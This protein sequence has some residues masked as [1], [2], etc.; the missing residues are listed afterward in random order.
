MFVSVCLLISPP[1][2][3]CVLGVRCCVLGSVFSA[4]LPAWGFVLFVGARVFLLPP[5][6]LFCFCL[7]LRA[8]FGCLLCA[9]VCFRGVSGMSSVIPGVS[10][11]VCFALF[12]CV[13]LVF[14][15]LLGWL[16]CCVL[17]LFSVFPIFRFSGCLFFCVCCVLCL[18]VFFSGKVFFRNLFSADLRRAVAQ[19][20]AVQ[21]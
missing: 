13:F 4:F 6:C 16:A 19:R 17:F 15:F 7:G 10:E 3:F 20:K 9:Q 2:C 5:L 1:A 18:C 8:S 21:N 12:C 11:R 14:A